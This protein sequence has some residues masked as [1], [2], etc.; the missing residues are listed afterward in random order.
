MMDILPVALFAYNRPWHLQKTLDSLLKNEL[1]N[2]VHLTIYCDGQKTEN[3]NKA[4]LEVRAIAKAVQGVANLEVIERTVNL[5]LAESIIT[6]VREQCDCWG[7]VIVLE[8]DLV[9]SPYFLRYMRDALTRYEHESR[10]ISIHGYCY[11]VKKPLPTTFFLRG[12]DCWGWATWKRAWDLF[13]PSA[14]RLLKKLQE[15]NLEYDFNMQGNANY[16]RMLSDF[17][18]GKNNS[19]AIRWRASAFIHDKL[20]LYPGKSLVHNIGFDNSG[21]HCP[22]MNHFNTRISAEPVVISPIPIEENPNAKKSFSAFYR[23]L[24]PSFFRR[25][26][27][28]LGALIHR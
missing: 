23:S 15:K 6:G 28:Y 26:V 8:D 27:R 24:R 10:V 16:I 17:E 4:V 14:A 7:R 25:A 1:L 21:T 19:W 22:S 12:A 9:L 13:D 5:G 2:Q 11:P 3:D 20:T 18:A